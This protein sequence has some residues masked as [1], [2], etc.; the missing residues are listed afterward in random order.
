MGQKKGHQKGSP[1]S[2]H[3][4]LNTSL[5]LSECIDAFI[6]DMCT[7][8]IQ[9]PPSQVIA[10]GEL[11]IFSPSGKK[12]D[13]AGRYVFHADGIPSGYYQDFRQGLKVT[14]SA[15]SNAASS[16]T[17]AERKAYKQQMRKQAEARRIKQ[18]EEHQN[19]AEEARYIWQ[20]AQPASP[21]HAYLIK[22]QVQRHNL[23][24]YKHDLIIPLHDAGGKLW[25]I[26]RVG[27]NGFKMMLKGGRKRGNFCLIGAAL[28]DLDQL[29]CINMVEGWATGASVYETY[30]V[31]V[32]VAFDAGNLLPVTKAIKHRWPYLAM[33]LIADNDRKAV[34]EGR[35]NVGVESAKAVADQFLNVFVEVPQFPETAPLAL[36]D[37]NDLVNWRGDQAGGR[38]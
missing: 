8:G 19:A 32:I 23:K 4:K 6:D 31:P 25:S 9:H 18:E 15:G 33:T 34:A 1:Q 10:D 38:V 3:F 29:D 12:G 5:S 17:P 20:H 28:S 16:M 22:K 27:S 13:T 2:S 26:Q 24:Q 36:S 37:F 35:T 7:N 30:D 11:H 14:W 21:N